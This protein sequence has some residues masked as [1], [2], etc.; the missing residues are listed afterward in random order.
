[1]KQNVILEGSMLRSA[2]NTGWMGLALGSCEEASYLPNQLAKSEAT[3]EEKKG[4]RDN[5][6]DTN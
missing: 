4:D 2:Y 3:M 1:M 6:L 5:R